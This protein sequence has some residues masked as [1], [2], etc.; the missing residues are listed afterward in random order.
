MM[1]TI[2]RFGRTLMMITLASSALVVMANAQGRTVQRIRPPGGIATGNVE[3]H[4]LYDSTY[5]RMRE[6]FVYTPPGYDARAAAAYPLLLAFDGPDY[7]DTIPLPLILDTLLA[8]RHAPAFV[9]VLV[10]DSSFAVR[11]G[12]LANQPRFATYL[13]EQLIPWV[14]ANYHVTRDPHRTIVTGS[15][16]GGLASAYVAFVRPD[17]FGNVLSQSGAFWRGAAGNNG[18]PYEWLT[19]QYA[20]APKKDIRFVLDVGAL[21]NNR[22]LG[23]SGPNFLEASRRFA[24]TIVRKGYN[25]VAYTEVPGGVH[26]PSSWRARL[27]NGIVSLTSAWSGESGERRINRALDKSARNP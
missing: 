22:T 25:P 23:G 24:E 12:D 9:A 4:L 10:A 18:E 19:G 1:T 17:L 13:G 11:L 7:L 27:A 14:R 21:E 15:S 3:R 2:A 8:G 16:A 6:V 5:R 26:A 20:A